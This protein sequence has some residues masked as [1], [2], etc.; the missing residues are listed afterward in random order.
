L[1]ATTS[2]PIIVRIELKNNNK[3]L[4]FISTAAT[5]VLTDFKH[6][7][8]RDIDTAQNLAVNQAKSGS[9]AN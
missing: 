2:H 6:S 3:K 7:F 9:P 4:P 1:I 5:L 8:N